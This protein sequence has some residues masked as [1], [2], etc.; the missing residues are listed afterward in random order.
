MSKYQQA[1]IVEVECYGE[2]ICME[3]FADLQTANEF[4]DL[5]DSPCYRVGLS[6]L[7]MYTEVPQFYK[8]NYGAPEENT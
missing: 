4:A 1:Y 7:N 3:A 8:E 5:F 2:E 6:A